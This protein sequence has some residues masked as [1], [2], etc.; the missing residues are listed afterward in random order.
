MIASAVFLWIFRGFFASNTLHSYNHSFFTTL[1]TPFQ[2]FE[3]PMLSLLSFC[4]YQTYLQYP[5][6][7]LEAPH[8]PLFIASCVYCYKF[9]RLLLFLHTTR[10]SPRG[11]ETGKQDRFSLFGL[12]IDWERGRYHT[13][14]VSFLAFLGVSSW[15]MH[16]VERLLGTNIRYVAYLLS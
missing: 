14:D 1:L 11:M 5:L 2:R 6:H 9:A 10:I 12:G 13:R 8:H 4:L 15:L 7:S 3:F 16:S